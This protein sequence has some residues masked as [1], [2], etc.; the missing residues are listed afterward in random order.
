[1]LEVIDSL[2][3]NY[4]YMPKDTNGNGCEKY[5]EIRHDTIAD[6]QYMVQRSPIQLASDS[7]L[8]SLGI[9]L[10]P[11]NGQVLTMLMYVKGA[12]T[13]ID[14]GTD[15]HILFTDGSKL[16]LKNDHILNCKGLVSVHFGAVNNLIPLKQLKQ[17]QIKTIRVSTNSSALVR[18]FDEATAETLRY[19]LE[20][21]TEGWKEEK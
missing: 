1:M 8:I 19:S 15:I 2:S 20:C 17:K 7:G 12:G 4:T 13:C 14:K 9:H 10:L 3:G 6:K 11:E 21:L 5:I 18:D 16:K